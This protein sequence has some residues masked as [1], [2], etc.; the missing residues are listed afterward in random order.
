M[1]EWLQLQKEFRIYLRAF[2]ANDF[3]TTHPWRIDEE[4]TATLVGRKYFVSKDY[5]KKWVSDSIFSPGNSLK[6]AVCLKDNHQHIGNAYLDQIDTF[7]QNAMFSLMIGEKEW[8]GKGIGREM[9]LLMLHYAF[10][11]MNLK[12]IFSYQLC[13]NIGSIKVHQKCGFQQEGVLR[14]AVFKHGELVNLNVMG[15]L[16]KEFD[17]TVKQLSSGL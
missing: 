4:V 10:Y 2:N 9:T 5:E 7:N 17:E 3:E 8:W 11:E 16:K 6:L 15:V 13:D 1:N 14:K 12:R